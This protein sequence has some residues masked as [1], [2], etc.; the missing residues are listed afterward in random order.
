MKDLNLQEAVRRREEQLPPMSSD[1]NER[2]LRRI[3]AEKVQPRHHYTRWIA[4]A[5]CL[6]LALGMTLLTLRQKPETKV[7]VQQTEKQKVP[8]TEPQNI[9]QETSAG[10]EEKLNVLSSQTQHVKMANVTRRIRKHNV[11]RSEEHQATLTQ[12]EHLT[13]ENEQATSPA[14]HFPDVP[15]PYLD[16]AA[17]AREI[18]SRGERFRNEI[19]Q[20]MK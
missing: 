14:E 17:Q 20:L 13:A 16:V 5:A 19:A 1:L 9:K 4:A 10:D 8:Q 7:V 11:P 12:E 6:I 15:D 3:E 2:L 18:R